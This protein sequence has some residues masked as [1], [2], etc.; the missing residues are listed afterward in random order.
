MSENSNLE[1][2]ESQYTDNPIKVESDQHTN[3]DYNHKEWD[4]DMELALL[5]AISRCKP[6]G[7]KNYINVQIKKPIFNK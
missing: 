3:L 4:A 1:T 7:K 2:S 5:N 6:V